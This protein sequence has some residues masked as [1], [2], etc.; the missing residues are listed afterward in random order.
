MSEKIEALDPQRMLEDL[1]AF[2][3]LIESTPEG[4]ALQLDRELARRLGLAAVCFVGS[5]LFGA[6]ASPLALHASRR[7]VEAYMQRLDALRY[8]FH[9]DRPQPPTGQG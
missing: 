9:E 7:K 6:L 4:G 8:P 3:R 1:E 2:A 5:Q